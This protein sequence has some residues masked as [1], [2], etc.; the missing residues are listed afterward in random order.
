MNKTI[1]TLA[2][3]IQPRRP[4]FVM[5]DYGSGKMY[6]TREAIKSLNRVPYTIDLSLLVLEDWYPLPLHPSLYDL[7]CSYLQ[8]FVK[9]IPGNGVLVIEEAHRLPP[10]GAGLVLEQML[11]PERPLVL[12]GRKPIPFLPI[13]DRCNIIKMLGGGNYQEIK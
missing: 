12:L 6:C 1:A 10:A 7:E 8:S 11:H 3:L 9:K 13:L 5:G 4:L 2:A